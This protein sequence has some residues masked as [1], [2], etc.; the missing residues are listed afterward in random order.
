MSAKQHPVTEQPQNSYEWH[1]LPTV[2]STVDRMQEARKLFGYALQTSAEETYNLLDHP[3][4]G[5]LPRTATTYITGGFSKKYGV[6]SKADDLLLYG[7]SDTMRLITPL[8]A[9]HS[10]LP[11]EVA[12]A[13]AAHPDTIESHAVAANQAQSTSSEVLYNHPGQTFDLSPEQNAIWITG[14]EIDL[15]VSRGCPA[16][17]YIETMGELRIEPIFRRFTVWAGELA[18][19][20]YFGHLTDHPA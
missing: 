12:L 4:P 9:M 11:K 2:P 8:L 10:H 19:H 14:Y 17:E 15:K 1:A 5:Y 3:A 16:V 13:I 7:I 6:E 18:V 20:S